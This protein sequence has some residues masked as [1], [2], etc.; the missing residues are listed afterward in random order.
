MKFYHLSDKPF[1]K[2]KKPK[3]LEIDY[4]PNGTLWVAPKGVWKGFA[5]FR[6]FKYEY[7]IDI[8]LSNLIIIDSIEDVKQ[9]NDLYGIDFDSGIKKRP[10][11]LIDWDKLRKETKTYGIYVKNAELTLKQRLDW[12]S[13]LDI[14]CIAIWDK[15]CIQSVTLLNPDR[16]A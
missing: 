5:D 4:K 15:K 13:T 10:F 2:F 16:G 7:E 1:S 9:L 12:Y 3:N 6:T 8:D 11:T 14:E